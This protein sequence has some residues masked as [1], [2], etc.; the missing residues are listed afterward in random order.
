MKEIAIFGLRCNG[1]RGWRQH[2]ADWLYRLGQRIDGRVVLAIDIEAS[3]VIDPSVVNQI[4][5]AGIDLMVR[6]GMSEVGN[7]AQE[8]LLRRA[9]PELF[10]LPGAADTAR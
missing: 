8:R 6:L 10:S 4:V 5:V 9:M 7:E 2:F 3:P 1:A